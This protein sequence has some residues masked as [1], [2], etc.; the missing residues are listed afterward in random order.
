LELKWKPK[1]SAG[2]AQAR[3]IAIEQ[4][5]IGV[6]NKA[7]EDKL[8]PMKTSEFCKGW[9]SALR[10]NYQI[11]ITRKVRSRRLF[12]LLRGPPELDRPL[13]DLHPFL[14]ISQA[15]FGLPPTTRA[16][17]SILP[18]HPITLVLI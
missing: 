8:H 13:R 15:R 18:P 7:L 2:E 6:S 16:Y 9:L 17:Q 11:L 10:E 1:F 12:W 3:W 4:S 5:G 14:L